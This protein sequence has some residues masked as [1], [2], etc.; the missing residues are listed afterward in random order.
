MFGVGSSMFD[1]RLNPNANAERRTPNESSGSHSVLIRRHCPRMIP[2]TDPTPIVELFRGNY[3][4]ELL[5]AAVSHFDVF[6]K[7]SKRAMTLDEVGAA[8]GLAPRA[9]IV[10]ITALRAMKFIEPD[11][12]GRLTLTAV[13]REHLV[14]G[15]RFYFGDYI[16]LR[17]DAPGT[18]GMVERLR[19]NRPAGYR[20]EETSAFIY[21][22][23]EESVM[24]EEASARRLTLGLAGRARNVAPVLA[25][26]LPLTGA[27]RLLD[28][29]GGTGIYSVELMKAN[30]ALRAVVW[31][32]PEV[33][34]VAREAAAGSG[35]E[36]RLELLPGD[37]FADAIPSGG[38]FDAI[39]L[40]NV[41]HDWDAPECRKLV[42]TCA[43]TLSPG[44]VLIV[45]D[46]F[47][48]DA[49]D[50]PLPVALYSAALFSVTEGRAYSAAE[51]GAFLREAGL[52][53]QPVI[54]T[55]VHCGALCGRK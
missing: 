49:L 36:A 21:K 45:H 43:D 44:G 28:V 2:T 22:K 26:Q 15:E 55:L 19:T 30:P 46:V 16:G 6:G 42:R 14:P 27:K 12:S 1:V 54:P 47:L 24:E 48:N 51:Y 52:T 23:G 17:A 8:I 4:T 34:K 35:V 9:A 10:L 31:D 37:M 18:L 39:L 41:L 53:P 3:A 11:G 40:S 50:G 5:T 38:G 20:P 33:L 32:R 13:A 29:G 25:A 7:L